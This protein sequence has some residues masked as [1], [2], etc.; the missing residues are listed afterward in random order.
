M[1]IAVALVVASLTP[2]PWVRLS[3]RKVCNSYRGCRLRRVV[4]ALRGSS[5][6]FERFW[7]DSRRTDTTSLAPTEIRL[8][9]IFF[10]FWSVSPSGWRFHLT[11]PW[12]R[13]RRQTTRVHAR[14]RNSPS[15][16]G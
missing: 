2:V 7:A 8:Q 10:E 5:S 13:Y 3:G 11:R 16:S 6:E 15:V 14:W 1:S 12:S 9:V 4:H